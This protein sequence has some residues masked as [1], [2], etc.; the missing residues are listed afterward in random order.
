VKP[1]TLPRLASAASE[2]E[3]ASRC[4]RAWLDQEADFAEGHELDAKTAARIPPRL[5]G[6]MLAPPEA[7]KLIRRLERTEPILKRPPT[8]SVRRGRRAKGRA[9]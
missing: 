2:A 7:L 8:P 5:I 6:R 3:R 1:I 4:R 9:R